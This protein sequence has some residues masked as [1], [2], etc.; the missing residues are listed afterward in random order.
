MPYTYEAFQNLKK[1]NQDLFNKRVVPQMDYLEEIL[2]EAITSL[3]STHPRDEAHIKEVQD[4]RNAIHGLAHPG[5]FT[6]G[7][8]SAGYLA[9]VNSLPKFL[10][11]N[12][13][14]NYALINKTIK[15]HENYQRN[16][17]KAANEDNS[18]I[19]R[20]MELNRELGAKEQPK[21]PEQFANMTDAKNKLHADD[22]DKT[23]N[24]HLKQLNLFFDLNYD[25]QL[26]THVQE[27]RAENYLAKLNN[28][29]TLTLFKNNTALQ[30]RFLEELLKNAANTLDPKDPTASG[31]SNKMKQ[32]A[33]ALYTV[34]TSADFAP[35]TPVLADAIEIVRGLPGLLTENDD[36]VSKAMRDCL[37]E[38][39]ELK[40]FYLP[41]DGGF[42]SKAILEHVTDLDDILDFNFKRQL[43]LKVVDEY[44]LM[45]N[46]RKESERKAEEEARQRDLEADKVEEQEAREFEKLQDQRRLQKEEQKRQE[47]EEART[48]AEQRVNYRRNGG[49]FS[50]PPNLF[51]DLDVT[52][53]LVN[54]A[55]KNGPQYQALVKFTNALGERLRQWDNYFAENYPHELDQEMQALP[56][57]A[58]QELRAPAIEAAL[59]AV[60]PED[61]RAFLKAQL[62]EDYEARVEAEQARLGQD[63]TQDQAVNSLYRGE[64]TRQRRDELRAKNYDKLAID[65]AR[66]AAPMQLAQAKRANMNEAEQ[67][68]FNRNMA[69]YRDM[70]IANRIKQ[71]LMDAYREGPANGA[72]MTDQ[73]PDLES[74]EAYHDA[75]DHEP[76]LND[77]YNLAKRDEALYEFRMNE[78]VDEALHD[79]EKWN[80]LNRIL[81]RIE[82]PEALKD[83]DRRKI[84][85]GCLEQAR[86]QVSAQEIDR[87]AEQMAMREL[88]HSFSQEE[89]EAQADKSLGFRVNDDELLYAWAREQKQREVRARVEHTRDGL[90]PDVAGF[91]VEK[92][93]AMHREAEKVV[94]PLSELLPTQEELAEPKF[95]YL[96]ALADDKNLRE[97]DREALRT[98]YE[99]YQQELSRNNGQPKAPDPPK[100][101][102]L[103]AIDQRIAKERYRNDMHWRRKVILDIDSRK[104]KAR[105]AHLD[106]IDRNKNQRINQNKKFL[107]VS[108]SFARLRNALWTSHNAGKELGAEN[109]ELREAANALDLGWTIPE[110]QKG[111]QFQA[112]QFQY[113]REDLEQRQEENRKARAPGDPEDLLDFKLGHNGAEQENPEDVPE[114]MN[115]T[116]VD[117]GIPNADAFA[118]NQPGKELWANKKWGPYVFSQ[119]YKDIQK[120]KDQE[121]VERLQHEVLGEPQQ[122]PEHLQHEVPGGQQENLNQEHIVGN[123]AQPQVQ[124]VEPGPAHS[125]SWWI[126]QLRSPNKLYDNK[127]GVKKLKVGQLVRIM[128]IR[129]LAE[130]VRGSK[131]KLVTKQLTEQDIAKKSEELLAGNVSFKKFVKKLT[132]DR[133]LQEEA[134]AAVGKGHGGGLDDMYS[135]YLAE[136]AKVGE[137][138]YTP[139]NKRWAPTAIQR[140]E[141][142]QAQ[143]PKANTT[144]EKRQ[145]MAEIIAV[146][147][148]VGAKH[149]H[150]SADKRLYSKLDDPAKLQNRM[151]DVETCL[152]MM[153]P[154][155]ANRLIQKA[156]TG[157]GGEM[158][159]DYK[160]LNT[161]N[162][163]LDEICKKNAAMDPGRKIDAAIAMALLQVKEQM[164]DKQLEHTSVLKTAE[165]LRKIPGYGDFVKNP[166]RQQELW[167]GRLT[168]LTE[169]FNSLH[170]Q[171]QNLNNQ[172]PAQR[173]SVLENDMERQNS[174]SSVIGGNG[175]A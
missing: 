99:K 148:L 145:Y 48:A 88:A 159:E 49:T 35:K 13:S 52:A 61:K 138:L 101:E 59:N 119:E 107:D 1:S 96:Q 76:A 41:K 63:A 161:V 82:A 103:T 152:I 69:R 136:Q 147:E 150:T 104:E 117:N 81:E 79:E 153:D 142:L 102:G 77:Y 144:Y 163:H 94:Q 4:M 18:A 139:E 29:E 149:S 162:A 33:N 36:F 155:K 25:A 3:E 42:L 62:G 105:Q 143:L 27:E 73:F 23:L 30:M 20:L 17:E 175:N 64:L 7:S 11:D 85:D 131:D 140:I 110:L 129:S 28:P 165:T 121:E 158:M 22:K 87:E 164:G 130:S 45:E 26:E 118:G 95:D 91:G 93:R 100:L 141:A 43:Q 154:N 127:D 171:Q 112:Q 60:K 86:S 90:F 83:F 156:L 65:N 123:A 14:R 169:N 8:T 53:M 32:M 116:F 38:H 55:K 160:K 68:R 57:N 80:E 166:Q 157:H 122:E 125:A 2:K 34:R 98:A 108:L 6:W 120:Q 39:P 51:N 151:K 111:K 47:E 72:F 115:Y 10:E 114:E 15:A 172:Q 109:T 132:D 37:K 67:L 124:P 168:D 137:P 71:A 54:S 89:V 134:I 97:Q 9:T 31:L 167:N 78:L 58:A 74:R 56:E 50:M 40:T 21:A 16:K 146:R 44:T 19:E 24:E 70:L 135:R 133:K 170:Q 113:K 174:K 92:M 128:A 106:A 126:K 75:H 46:E 12:G 173:L 66:L 84:L 5:T